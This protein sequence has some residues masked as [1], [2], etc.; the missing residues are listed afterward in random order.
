MN[1][2]APLQIAIVAPNVS[3]NMSGEAIK[4][5]QYAKHLVA[6]GAEVTLITHG[7]S[8]PHLGHFPEAV[9]VI[10]VED[11]FWQLFVWRSVVLRPLIDIPFFLAVRKIARKMHAETPE[12][13][14]HFL[15]P[16]SPITPRFPL[17]EAKCVL[18]PITGNIYYPPALSAREPFSLNWRRIFHPLS[19]R[20]VGALF[21][22]KSKFDSI[23]VSG[24]ARTRQS[25]KWAGAR[26]EQMTDVPDS[27]VSD[28]ILSRPPIVHEGENN[29]FVVNGRL[30]PHKGADL[31]IRAV[32]RTK[33]PITLDIFGKGPE[34]ARLRELIASLGLEER[35]HMRGWLP[36]HDD[37]L[38]EMTRYRAFVFPSM[39]EANGIVVQEALAMGLPVICLDWG[40]PAM[41]TSDETA[42]RIEPRSE[43]YII[44]QLAEQ[45]DDLAGDP[46]RAAR[47]AANGLDQARR[48]F[49]WGAVAATWRSGFERQAAS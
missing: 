44:A 7:R 11:D 36:S 26:D 42:A 14:F 40:G 21:H 23:L 47:L 34:E 1:S 29:R 28:K 2:Q 33:R 30:M 19:Q 16:V 41:L 20:F 27:G 45:M 22:D 5:Y 25:L 17:R 6:S 32:A 9:R 31:A 48:D 39:A 10:F 24:G 38:N 12:M 43:E 37:L 49:G 4:A 35:V 3:E 8:A 18:G 15:G 46:A 13:V